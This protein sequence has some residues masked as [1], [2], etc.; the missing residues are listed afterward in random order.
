[1]F[2]PKQSATLRAM[3]KTFLC[4]AALAL[5]LPVARGQAGPSPSAIELANLSEQVRAL[6]LQ[7]SDLTLQLDQLKSDNATLRAKL[8]AQSQAA[9]AATVAQ[10]NAAVADL[11]ALVQS[12]DQASRETVATQIKKLAEQTNAA[13]DALAKSQAARPVVQTTFAYVVQANDSL[14]LIAKKTGAKA[15]DIINANKITDANKLRVG[16]KLFIPGGKLP[17]AP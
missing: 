4:G 10:L 2:S 3:W 12:T 13:L 6:S 1:L 11:R 8:A 16:Q 17:P 5:A 7:V 9:P 14:A 15:Q